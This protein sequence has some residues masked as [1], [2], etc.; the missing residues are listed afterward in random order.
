MCIRDRNSWNIIEQGRLFEG[1]KSMRA[2]ST[3]IFPEVKALCPLKDDKKVDK[4]EDAKSELPKDENKVDA[5]EKSTNEEPKMLRVKENS[6][7]GVFILLIGM[8]IHLYF[9]KKFLSPED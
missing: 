5:A 2:S 9:L 3:K 8:N 6:S 4:V 1:S 7:I